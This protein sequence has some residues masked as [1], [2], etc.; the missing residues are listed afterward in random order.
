MPKCPRCK[1][2]I[3]KTYFKISEINDE[4]TEIEMF[5]EPCDDVVAWAWIGDYDWIEAE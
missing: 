3:E 2:E 1:K 5:C 4:H